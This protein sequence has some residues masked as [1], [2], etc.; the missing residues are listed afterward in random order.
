MAKLGPAFNRLLTASG[1]SNLADGIFIVALP[2]LAVSLTR[3]PALVAGVALAQR[4]PWLI[5]ALPAGA[6]ADRLDRRRTMVRVDFLRVAVMGT[7]AAAVAADVASMPLLYVA[8]IVLGVGETL[9]DTASQSILPAIV[10]RDR[11]T[12]ANGRLQAVE[13]T[14][15]N[16]VGPSLGGLLAAVALASTFAS[17]AA[18]YLVAAFCLIRIPGSFRPVRDGPATSIRE[19]IAEGLRFVWHNQTLRTL[20]IMLGVTNLAFQAHFSVFVL[21]ATG[22]MG[23]SEAGYGLL[24]ASFALGAI[25]APLT[26]PWLERT[27]GRARTLFGVIVFFGASLAVPAVT[28]NVAANVGAFVVASFG[29]VVWNVITVSLRQRITPD[30]LLGRMNSAYR[31]MGWGT[32]PIG[33]LLGGVVAEVWG[34]RPTF[35]LAAAIHLPLLLGF[36]LLTEARISEAEAAA[37]PVTAG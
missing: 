32:M 8:A 18:G 12:E 33:A 36:L 5:M 30:H 34:L 17:S 16:F 14:T 19:D 25:A 27:F 28:P 1:V 26:V 3:S 35:A 29:S 15:N 10:G 23:L 7:I 22:P 6:L 37:G 21:F 4:L 13:L 9:F 24:T 2:L 31:L 11:L 20:A